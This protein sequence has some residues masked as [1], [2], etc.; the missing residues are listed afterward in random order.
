M[1]L[2]Q[3]KRLAIVTQDPSQRGGVL[4]LAAYMFQR[5]EACGLSPE[6][7]YYGRFAAHPELHV[8]SMNLWRGELNLWVRKKILSFERMPA[9]ALGAWFPEWEPNRLRSNALW[10]RAFEPF[11]AFILV[12]GSAHTGFPLVETEKEFAAWVSSTVSEDRKERLDR[13]HGLSSWLERRALPTVMEMESRV[14]HRA[15]RILA[16]SEDAK[17]HVSQIAK[18]EVEVWP[19]PIDTATFSP[20]LR[21]EDRT[22]FLFVGR[23]N[24]PRKRVNLFLEACEALASRKPALNVTATIVS[25]EFATSRR[26]NFAIEHISEISEPD[27]IELYRSSTVLL[28]TST[29]EGLGIAAMEA[30]ACGLPVISTRCGGPETFLEDGIDGFF[31]PD[32]PDTIADRMDAIASSSALQ[33]TMGTSARERMVDH[34]SQTIWNKKFEAMLSSLIHS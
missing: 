32:D 14:L 4:R 34:F 3:N 5:A 31:V 29:Q 25:S 26:W 15:E 10:R 24:D 30:M 16:V 1:A 27:L 28:V 20:T 11:D 7:L 9:R 19:Y 18:K 21:R 6:L 33:H 22:R 23:A 12:T 17:K 8:S 2:A 13:S